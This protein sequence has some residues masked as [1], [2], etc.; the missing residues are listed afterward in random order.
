M[1]YTHRYKLGYKKKNQVKSPSSVSHP[2]LG[3]NQSIGSDRESRC[4]TDDG[5]AGLWN[6][7]HERSGA[8]ALEG[9]TAGGSGGNVNG[10]EPHPTLPFYKAVRN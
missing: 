8:R 5:G 1:G 6:S 3:S 9:L 10:N 4:D 2:E 7:G